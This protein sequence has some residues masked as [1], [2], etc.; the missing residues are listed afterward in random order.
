MQ[1][2][3][4]LSGHTQRMPIRGH[5]HHL[6]LA[7]VDRRRRQLPI[8]DTSG[9]RAEQL[10]LELRLRLWAVQRAVRGNQR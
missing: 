4:T 7:R 2:Q 9:R 5:H 8:L 6:M 1:A 3:R 10:R